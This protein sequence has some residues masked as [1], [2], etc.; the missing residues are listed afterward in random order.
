MWLENPYWLVGNP[1][2]LSGTGVSLKSVSGWG[3]FLTVLLKP[4]FKLF[5]WVVLVSTLIQK[6]KSA[7][8]R[9]VNWSISLFFCF[10]QPLVYFY[11]QKSVVWGLFIWVVRE[12]IYFKWSDFKKPFPVLITVLS[13]VSS[14]N[15]T[16]E[17]SLARSVITELP[18]VN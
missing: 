6:R 7:L 13:L 16:W 3:L 4:S 2:C 18:K 1:L 9:L 12:T 14:S 11:P 5:G 17:N 15:F 10:L 8:D